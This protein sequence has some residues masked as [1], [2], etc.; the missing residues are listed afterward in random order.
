MTDRVPGAPGQYSA[1]IGKDELQKLQ[2][3][4]PFAITLTRDDRPIKEGTPYSK[5]AVLPD[6]VAQVLCPEVTDPAPKD[7]FAALQEKKA[8][9]IQHRTGSVITATNS[10]YTPLK[11]L[12]LYGN[13]NQNGTPTPEAPVAMES[14]GDSGSVTV[15]VAGSDVTQTLTV[16][17]PNGLPGIPMASGGNYTDNTGQQWVCDEI[18]YSRGVYVRRIGNVRFDGSEDWKQNNGWISGWTNYFAIR[19]E[20]NSLG[21]GIQAVNSLCSHYRYGSGNNNGNMTTNYGWFCFNT[22]I[23]SIADWKAMLAQQYAAGTPVTV[24][25]VSTLDPIETPLPAEELAAYA[26]LHTNHPTTTVYNDAGA[27]MEMTY[28]TPS[29]AVQMVHSPKDV[30]KFLSVDQHGCVVLTQPHIDAENV[31]SLSEKIQ[32]EVSLWHENVPHIL[33]TETTNGWHCRLWSDGFVQ[34]YAT[35]LEGTQINEDGYREVLYSLPYSVILGPSVQI[36]ACG[37]VF[38]ANW[39]IMAVGTGSALRVVFEGDM[40]SKVSNV[41]LSIAGYVSE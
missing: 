38:V 23:S 13:T 25:Y 29:T 5:A 2:E 41:N 14:A 26:K 32:E 19:L 12:K 22:S 34:M 11:G 6:A 33:R 9:V 39:D 4:E 16:S 7:A 40:G 28:Y 15:T 1:V 3:G 36:T 35:G 10:A 30:G 20:N 21:T 17:T 31:E 27:G 24:Q 37:K 18:D 8:D